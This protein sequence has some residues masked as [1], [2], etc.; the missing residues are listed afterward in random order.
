LKWNRLLKSS[1]SFQMENI[2]TE[3]STLSNGGHSY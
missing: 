2:H 1:L 3:L